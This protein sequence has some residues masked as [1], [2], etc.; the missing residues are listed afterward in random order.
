MSGVAERKRTAAKVSGR[1]V[2]LTLTDGD[3]R[4]LTWIRA[5]RV[6]ALRGE[7][8]SDGPT[9]IDLGAE[10]RQVQEGYAE[11]LSLLERVDFPDYYAAEG[12]V[13]NNPPLSAILERDAALLKAAEMAGKADGL[14]GKPCEP[15]QITATWLGF[16]HP[17]R[18]QVRM[19]L[20]AAY[21]HA[22]RGARSS[23]DDALPCAK[24][25]DQAC[26]GTLR[27]P[28][29][30]QDTTAA[31]PLWAPEREYADELSRHLLGVPFERLLALNPGGTH[32]VVVVPTA[33]AVGRNQQLRADFAALADLYDRAQAERGDARRAVRQ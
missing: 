25:D 15:S 28:G 29:G 1:F 7:Q 9:C 18:E 3:R 2:R 21:E 14:S 19:E 4:G 16:V 26:S 27:A 20:F 31:A 11:V 12:I 23:T 30:V 8:G 10:R 33:S 24:E 22:Y 32:P 17:L 5:D 13:E 6:V